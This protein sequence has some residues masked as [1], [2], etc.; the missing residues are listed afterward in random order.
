MELFADD[1]DLCW[2]ISTSDDC[3][4]FQSDVELASDWFDL[5]SLQLKG[6]KFRVL[7][8]TREKNPTKTE[9]RLNG[10]PLQSVDQ[11]KHLRVWVQ[12]TLPW[13]YHISTISAKARRILGLIPMG[14]LVRGD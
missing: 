11:H 3:D 14:H 8:I 4:L 7:Y 5:S 12:S 13:D 2:K 10:K 1:R 6:E 9:Y